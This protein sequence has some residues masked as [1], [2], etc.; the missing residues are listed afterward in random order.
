[1]K[2]AISIPDQVFEAAEAIAQQ[3]GVSRSEFYT[4]ALQAYLEKYSR[5]Q[6]LDKLNEVYAQESSEADLVLAKMQAMS[7]PK[8]DW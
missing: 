7:L 3:L 2:T 8:E 1:M 5:S 4:K 6:R